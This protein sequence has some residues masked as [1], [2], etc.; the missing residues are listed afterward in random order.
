MACV[1]GSA[2]DCGRDGVT[3]DGQRRG[4]GGLL[5]KACRLPGLSG[6]GRRSPAVTDDGR[7]RRTHH[8]EWAGGE[9]LLPRCGA[10]RCGRSASVP[11]SSWLMSVSS[12]EPAQ[13]ARQHTAPDHA[14]TPARVGTGQI[15]PA[16]RYLRCRARRSWPPGPAQPVRPCLWRAALALKRIRPQRSRSSSEV[17]GPQQQ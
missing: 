17:S 11:V 5:R 12:Q 4:R 13:I 2:A 1:A 10:G 16:D 9:Q 8:R 14:R 7:V 15:D 6:A 3:K